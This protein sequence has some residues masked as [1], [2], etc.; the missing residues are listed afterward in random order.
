MST[1]Q[2]DTAYLYNFIS[3]RVLDVR[4]FDRCPNFNECVRFNGENRILKMPVPRYHFRHLVSLGADRVSGV[5]NADFHGETGLGTHFCRDICVS[6]LNYVPQ[7]KILSVD[8]TTMREV[9]ELAFL[10]V[11]FYCRLKK[12]SH[13]LMLSMRVKG[14]RRRFVS[15]FAAIPVVKKRDW[16]DNWFMSTFR[17]LATEHG[18]ELCWVVFLRG[19]S[20]VECSFIDRAC[21]RR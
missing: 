21:L 3:V 15:T 17:P 4:V 9:P 14:L 11:L 10:R 18:F 19:L 8:M 13:T 7:N 12:G 20:A 1:K 6:M 16:K 5:C 2:T